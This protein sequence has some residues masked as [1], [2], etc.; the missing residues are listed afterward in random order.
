MLGAT[1]ELR[2]RDG[3]QELA[4]Y[5]IELPEGKYI[6]LHSYGAVEALRNMSN[7]TLVIDSRAAQ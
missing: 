1:N 6:L 4:S 5:G 3:A 2:Q 7:M